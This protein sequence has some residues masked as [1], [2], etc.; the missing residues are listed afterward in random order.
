MVSKGDRVAIIRGKYQKHGFG[1]YLEDYGNVM[2]KVC[3]DGDNRTSRN[4]WKTS[5]KP[6]VV[7]EEEKTQ[8]QDE[9]VTLTR[10]EY[11]AMIDQVASIADKLQQL[12]LKL[13]EKIG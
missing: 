13:K 12:Q 1:T 9:T 5:I 7:K 3:I 2:C 6:V 11:E 10:N 8:Q 4:I